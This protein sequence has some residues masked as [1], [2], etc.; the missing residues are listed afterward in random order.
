MI[1]FRQVGVTLQARP[2]SRAPQRPNPMRAAQTAIA[3][4]SCVSVVT[5]KAV[6]AERSPGDAASSSLAREAPAATH[7]VRVFVSAVNCE[8]NRADAARL[9][10]LAGTP[11]LAVEVIFAGI[12]DGDTIVLQNAKADLGLTVATRLVRG[13]ELEQYKSIGGARLPMALVVKAK[14]LKTIIA[15]ESMPRTLSLLE[16]S[17]SPTAGQ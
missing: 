11:G 17:M 15:G 10:S 2:V 3:V 13:K 7:M 14:Q 9:N 8:M 5:C 16:A 12:A 4:I 1:G 6:N